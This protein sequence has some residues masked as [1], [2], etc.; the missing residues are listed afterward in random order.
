MDRG[1]QCG[2]KWIAITRDQHIRRKPN[3]IAAIRRSHALIFV[4]NSGNLSAA[5]TA[6]ILLKA[7]P[8]IYR[9]AA[10]TARPALYSIRKD[11]SVAALA[12]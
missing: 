4:F 1:S 2:K 12:L 6:S 5:D 8:R 9:V 10:E 11:G 3:E 7:L